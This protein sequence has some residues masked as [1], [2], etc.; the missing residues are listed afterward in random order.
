VSF[1]IGILLALLAAPAWGQAAAI[2]VG[3]AVSETGA[4]AA[5]A[6]DYRKALL[7]W[8]D[9]VNAAGGLLGRRVELRLLDDQ[10]DARRSGELYAELIRDKADL[11]IGPF[12]SAATLMASAE[13]ERSQR[14]LI[15]GAGP[16]LAVHKRS[17]RY[18]FQTTMPN[19]SYGIGVLELARSAGLTKLL[20]LSR[21][22][23]AVRE[24]AD[25]TRERALKQGFQSAEV[26]VY[27]VGA[28]DFSPLVSK[29]RAGVEA[30]IAFGEVRD[31]AEM[32]RSFRKLDYAPRVFFA[33]SASD[34]RLIA[35]VGQDAE[36]AL[37]IREYHPSL[38]TAGNA[39]FAAAFSA[40][41]SAAPSFAA[42]QGYAAASVLAEAVRRTGSLDQAKLRDTL[43]TMESETVLGGYRVDAQSGEQRAARP[44]VVQIQRGRPQ[45]VWPP[46]LQS[47]TLEPYPQWEE[48]RR[49]E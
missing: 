3:A 37:G 24:M 22:D 8:Q 16:A 45:V 39:R 11:L 19:S 10:S 5:L 25:A 40:K 42:A 4:L 1:L 48:R 30:W 46:A 6:A 33:R 29:A 17:P 32:I 36:H 44:A 21:D 18:L 34:P 31:A 26:A 38:E 47:A 49:L 2:V 27:A 15:N 7:V 13:T 9:E 41:W 23:Q 43:A 35:L 12:G 20:I 14:V 28:E